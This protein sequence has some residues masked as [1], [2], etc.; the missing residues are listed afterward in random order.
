MTT[1]V[2][3]P[4]QNF[5]L[6]SGDP[7]GLSIPEAVFYQLIGYSFKQIADTVGHPDNLIDQL[8]A[9]L[10]SETRQTIKDWFVAHRNITITLNWPRDS[11]GLPF[12]AVVTESEDEAEDLAM[13]GDY[14]GM[15]V[16]GTYEAGGQTS[17]TNFKV[18]LDSNTSIVIVADDPNLV[19]YIGAVLR[20]I[21]LRNK[22]DLTRLY[23]V[24]TLTV[25]QQDLRWD[26]RFIPTFAYMRMLSLRYKTFFGF[27]V[28]EKSSLITSLALMVSTMHEGN[29]VIVNVP[30]T[31]Q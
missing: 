4:T 19:I 30:N 23:D 10:R 14:A 15:H 8:F 9:R 3:D 26:E 16:F 28:S 20:F 21:F 7:L 22:E 29:E 24:H 27:S 25:S 6:A 18:G 2:D 11:V 31:D 5:T 12:I 1:I 17:N 13:L